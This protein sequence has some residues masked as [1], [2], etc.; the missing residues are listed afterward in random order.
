[1]RSA[2]TRD[3]RLSAVFE[4]LGD[5]RLVADVGCDH[6]YLS[7][8]LITEGRAERAISSDISPV[9]VQ[10]AA[11]LARKLGID[12]SMKAVCADGLDSLI[13]EEPPYAIAICG[14]GGELIVKILERGRKNAERADLIVMQ[15]MR[16]EAELRE[17]LVKNGFTIE[18][19]RVVRERGRWYQVI[20]AAPGGGNII[21]EWFPKEW[22]RFGW[23]MA[24]NREPELLPL[25][26]HYRAV[27]E[28]ELKKAMAKGRSPEAMIMELEKTEQL[29][30][31]M[32]E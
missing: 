16:G 28:R 19:E 8:R 12:G 27:Y 22:Y 1:M 31:F 29:I 6:G 20:S 3:A 15:P 25:L 10:K 24:E 26:K 4:L 11:K 9:S 14:M 18:A 30:S 5:R 2:L 23:V 21:P 7:A 17:Y 32:S 13:C